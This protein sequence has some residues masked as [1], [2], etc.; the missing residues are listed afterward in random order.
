MSECSCDDE[1]FDAGFEYWSAVEVSNGHIAVYVLSVGLLGSLFIA[2]LILAVRSK[3]KSNILHKQFQNI[4][5]HYENYAAI[6]RKHLESRLDETRTD[7]VKKDLD[8]EN[9]PMFYRSSCRSSLLLK[10][11]KYIDD[12]APP[13]IPAF[14]PFEGINSKS[15]RAVRRLSAVRMFA[16]LAKSRDGDGLS[17]FT[18]IAAP[19]ENDV[20]DDDGSE[21]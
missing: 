3:R 15:H 6:R 8:E 5:I 7:N 18:H 10:A 21:D 14:L 1:D 20:S 9:H 16:E 4:H 11:K 2:L 17:E 13:Q 19:K 12:V